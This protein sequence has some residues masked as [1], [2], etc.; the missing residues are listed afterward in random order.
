[1]RSEARRSGVAPLPWPADSPLFLRRFQ[2]IWTGPHAVQ[3]SATG[4]PSDRRKQGSP[5][6]RVLVSSVAKTGKAEFFVLDWRPRPFRIGAAIEYICW[7]FGLYISRILS[8]STMR[9]SQCWGLV[10]LLLWCSA[11][12]ASATVINVDL[13]GYRGAEAAPPTY[14]GTGPVGTGT[15]WNGLTVPNVG[16]QRRRLLRR[17][18]F[19]N[20][21]RSADDPR[22]VSG[23]PERQRRRL[24]PSPSAQSGSITNG[25]R[26]STTTNCNRAVL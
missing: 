7:P 9:F 1:M 16:T 14:S 18:D 26:H 12:R 5:G 6:H 11:H 25:V 10:A 21:G 23:R 19:N 2:E 20:D 15:T 8:R 4:A 17:Y 3:L 22:Y 24:S 13:G